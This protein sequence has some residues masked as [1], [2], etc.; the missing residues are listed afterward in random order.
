MVLT[1][2]DINAITFPHIDKQVADNIF[3]DHP[4]L[5]RLMEKRR[6]YNG[7][8]NIR[9]P[10][11]NVKN[12]K[13]GAFT[14]TD[15]RDISNPE[16]LTDARFEIKE[17]FKPATITDKQLDENSGAAAVVD[18]TTQA[19]RNAQMSLDDDFAGDVWGT[20]D[21]DPNTQTIDGQLDML[22]ASTTY[23][24]IAVADFANWIA[25]IDSTTTVMSIGALMNLYEDTSEGSRT[26]TV[27]HTTKRLFAKLVTLLQ[28]QQ[29]FMQASKAE[30]GFMA[31]EF[32]GIPIFRSSFVPGSGGGTQDNFF[33]FNNEN[34]L[35]MYVSS[36]FP[37][38]MMP[39][40]DMK[41]QFPQIT[42][43]IEAK[44]ALVCNNRRFQG[45]MTTLDPNL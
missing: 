10:I 37:V 30:I 36:K 44:L 14:G 23:G 5:K 22:S 20:S 17:Y 9:L 41:P 40:K 33:V 2:T 31:L 8:L 7:G 34:F 11:M 12:D 1:A 28:A 25:Q 38:K 13:G 15:A 21:D 39:W 16:F 42:T 4:A 24:G 43:T 26:P 35:F 6:R 19:A 18:F 45:A 3:N 29:R 32:L 27:G